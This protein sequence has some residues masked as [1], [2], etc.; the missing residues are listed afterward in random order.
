MV[1]QAPRGR[2]VQLVLAVAQ[3]DPPAPLDPPEQAEELLVQ[4]DH[5]VW[6]ERMVP[7]VQRGDKDLL[8]RSGR[9]EQMVLMALR[10]RKV[11]SVQ[12]VSP[13]PTELPVHKVHPVQ[14]ESMELPDL[15]GL[16]ALTEWM[17]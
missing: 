8:V 16:P 12:A 3:Q 9:R 1:I 10:V 6:M 17:E 2:Q 5:P 15:K 14:M 13:V 4:Q 7:T 11:L